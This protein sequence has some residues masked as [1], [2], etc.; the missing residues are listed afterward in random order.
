M[1]EDEGS[2]RPLTSAQNPA[3]SSPLPLAANTTILQCFQE[4]G[5]PGAHKLTPGV[6]PVCPCQV[7]PLPAHSQIPEV[8]THSSEKGSSSQELERRQ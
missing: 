5:D 7:P 1:T 6:L 8:T 3:H 4:A 2:A